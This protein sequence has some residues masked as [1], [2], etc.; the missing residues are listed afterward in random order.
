MSEEVLHHMF[1]PFFTT[2][3][4]GEGTGLGLA[5][6]HG[7]VEQSG[8]H[9]RVYSELGVGTTFKVYLPRVKSSAEPLAR[10]RIAG[11]LPRG[12]ETILVVEDEE[13]VRRVA[14]RVL[15]QC[16]YV[17][18]DVADPEEALEA[19]QGN[20]EHIDLLLTDVVM[21][22]MSGRDLARRLLTMRPDMKVL[23]MSGYVDNTIAHHGVLDPG[24]AFI[25]KPFTSLALARKVRSV[26]DVS[27]PDERVETPQVD[28]DAQG[29][30]SSGEILETRPLTR[31]SMSALPADLVAAM[32]EA[33]INADV[34][35]LCEL[36]DR[37]EALDAHVAAELRGLAG[38]YEYDALLDLLNAEGRE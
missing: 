29:V 22:R 24:T 8:G 30:Q 35:Q 37:V 6:V 33:T 16:G 18:S 15:C 11:H 2:K 4:K 38:R 3:K 1:E 9:I 23:Y 32:R 27:R 36:I 19:A 34:E 31:E 13:T 12:T 17:V 25:H 14:S 26:L 5:V 21:P 20:V 10:E 7:I 28:L